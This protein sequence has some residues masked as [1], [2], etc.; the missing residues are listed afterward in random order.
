[1]A[2]CM[3]PFTRMACV[4]AWPS[5]VAWLT[6]CVRVSCLVTACRSPAPTHSSAPVIHAPCVP[7]VWRPLPAPVAHAAIAASLFG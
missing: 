4:V 5:D 6:E 2:L 7:G 3:A 1:M